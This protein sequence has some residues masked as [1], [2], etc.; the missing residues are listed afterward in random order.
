MRRSQGVH[1]VPFAAGCAPAVQRLRIIGSDSDFLGR[2][3]GRLMHGGAGG[4]GRQ[5]DDAE[6]GSDPHIHSGGSSFMIEPPPDLRS[7]RGHSRAA[8]SFVAASFSAC[9]SPAVSPLLPSSITS[10]S[11]LPVNEKGILSA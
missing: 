3:T 1:I 9:P 6:R 10:L 2:P 7:I 11:S 5:R 4:E 8:V